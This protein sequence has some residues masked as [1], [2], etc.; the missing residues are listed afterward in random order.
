M[1]YE[2]VYK[3]VK[4]MK[5]VE[6]QG[7]VYEDLDKLIAEAADEEDRR[8]YEQNAHSQLIVGA[9]GTIKFA[10]EIPEGTPAEE[11]EKAKRQGLEVSEDGKYIITKSEIGKIEDGVLYMYDKST[12]L[13]GKE[14]VK[15]ST[16][17]EGELNL[18]TTVYKRV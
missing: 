16:D 14:W 11:I 15:I 9:D 12:F 10:M 1:N 6:G 8:I 5:M 18:V 13:T 17:A 2:G 3:A 4:Q 7:L